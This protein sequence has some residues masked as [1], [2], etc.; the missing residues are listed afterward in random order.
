M[1]SINYGSYDHAD[2]PRVRR[3]ASRLAQMIQPYLVD[4][5][6]P[7]EGDLPVDIAEESQKI[8]DEL[9]ALQTVNKR[10]N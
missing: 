5:Q 9:N 1:F 2:H 8:F 10:G 6:I 4:G 7:T 3:L